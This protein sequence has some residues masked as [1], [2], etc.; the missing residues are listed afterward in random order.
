MAVANRVDRSWEKE[1]RMKGEV[2][3]QERDEER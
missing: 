3:G 1:L 2:E